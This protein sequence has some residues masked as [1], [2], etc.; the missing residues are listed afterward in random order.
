MFSIKKVFYY[1]FNYLK[2]QY[3]G[4]IKYMEHDF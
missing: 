3:I 1:L 4:N 2:Y